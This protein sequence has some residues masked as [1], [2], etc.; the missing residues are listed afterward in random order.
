MAYQARCRHGRRTVLAG[1]LGM[2]I[3]LLQGAPAARAGYEVCGN[4]KVLAIFCECDSCVAKEQQ[5]AEA[6]SKRAI[7]EAEK[8]AEKAE[9]KRQEKAD[10]ERADA[11]SKALD[12][13]VKTL[14]EQERQARRDMY[15]AIPHGLAEFEA[16]QKRM[17]AATRQ[18]ETA[19]RESL[20][21]KLHRFQATTAKLSADLAELNKLCSE[22]REDSRRQ[23]EESQERIQRARTGSGEVAPPTRNVQPTTI[24]KRTAADVYGR[25][26]TQAGSP[27]LGTTGNAGRDAHAPAKAEGGPPLPVRGT[28]TWQVEDCTKIKGVPGLSPVVAQKSTRICE[29]ELEQDLDRACKTESNDIRIQPSAT[30]AAGMSIRRW[31]THCLENS[32]STGLQGSL[33][34]AHR[35]DVAQGGATE[36][37][38]GLQAEASVGAS[39]ES[40]YRAVGYRQYSGTITS[41]G[42]ELGRTFRTDWGIVESS[43]GVKA[44]MSRDGA[45]ASA[46]VGGGVYANRT[47]E[48]FHASKSFANPLN[49]QERIDCGIHATGEVAVGIG[50]TSSLGTA[51]STVISATYGVG[52]GLRGEVECER[53]EIV[54]ESASGTQQ[55]SS[56]N[57]GS[58]SP[59]LNSSVVTTK[60]HS[61]P[62]QSTASGNRSS[63]NS[64]SAAPR[65][66]GSGT[67]RTSSSGHFAATPSSGSYGSGSSRSSA[68][69]SSNGTVFSSSSSL[70]TVPSLPSRPPPSGRL[71]SAPVTPVRR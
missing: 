60:T 41:Q 57:R 47:S 40:R 59:P 2:I 3:L 61:S 48:T 12:E 9:R 46:N 33:D 66:G 11:K 14:K 5:E 30:G 69:A 67:S 21:F 37:N 6:A 38:A 29:R 18:H 23:N 43:D 22:G 28:A 27:G 26:G 58:F 10:R 42:D 24:A 71:S 63:Y 8:A 13:R 45:S 65:S 32:S 19:E 31:D 7:E 1:I 39:S 4:T 20:E 64:S 15:D 17:Q 36:K 51:N 55:P 44:G 62:G 49:S 25:N 56:S 68:G 50:M 16:A 52:A 35:T 54:P 34:R 70:F 53:K